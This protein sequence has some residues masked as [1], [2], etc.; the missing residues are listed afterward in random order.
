MTTQELLR[1]AQAAKPAIVLADTG[2]KNEALLAMAGALEA[3]GQTVQQVD[4]RG[5]FELNIVAIENES[6]VLD[7]VR[8]DYCFRQGDILFVAGGASGLD[9]FTDWVDN[10]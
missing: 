7:Y 5:R 2:R 4:L 3:V 9:K 8:P 6:T 10:A 1:R